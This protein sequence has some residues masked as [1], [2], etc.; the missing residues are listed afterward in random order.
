MSR[1][2]SFLC[3]GFTL[4][5]L[6]C[7]LAMVGVLSAI[8]MPVYQQAQS[9]SQ[10]QLAKLALVKSAQ[11]LEQAAMATGSYPAELP[12]SVWR[13][14]GF[15]YRLSLVSQAQSY[16]LT[17]TPYQRQKQDDCGA[18]S[19]DQTGQRGAQGDVPSCWS[20]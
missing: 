16:V 7:V 9:R 19:L 11:W 6:L 20:K 15:T 2:S 1:P 10:R 14:P 5:E 13:T 12:E 3:A 4:I 17:A 18:L 8:A